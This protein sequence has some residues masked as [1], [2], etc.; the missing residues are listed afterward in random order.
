M[1]KLELIE[2][3]KSE[4]DLTKNEAKVAV[5]L[6][7]DKMSS[8]LTKGDRIEIRGLCSFSVKRYDGY[9]GRNPKTGEKIEVPPK[10]LPF[11][12]PGLELKRQVDGCLQN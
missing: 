12:K 2:T 10:K 6:F 3:L 1:N 4:N 9:L 8:A 11:F 7:F 5:N